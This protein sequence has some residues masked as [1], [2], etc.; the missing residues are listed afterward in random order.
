[1]GMKQ[2]T[3]TLNWMKRQSVE[4]HHSMSPWKNKFNVTSSEG[5][6]WPLFHW[7]AEGVTLVYI[8]P[9]DQTIK[10]DLYKLNS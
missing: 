8:M 6:S 9:E 4:W 7:D 10:S 1:M 2:G 3:I 5:K